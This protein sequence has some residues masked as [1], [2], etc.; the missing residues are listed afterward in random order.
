M[1]I[2]TQLYQE[3]DKRLLLD[4]FKANT[5]KYFLPNEINW[6]SDYLDNEI[7]Q[8]FVVKAEDKIIG[9]GGI[10]TIKEEGIGIISWGM[11]H[12]DYHK[13]GAGKALLE[14]RLEVLRSMKNIHTIRVRTAQ[15][16]YGFFEKFGFKTTKFEKDFWGPGLDLY[17]M[18][19]TR[20]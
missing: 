8:F 17:E 13:K 20:E 18:I 1:K 15:H 3:E 5:P 2:Q 11:I 7:E 10:N 9:C 6:F 16:T 12:P 4:I 14:Y 19:I